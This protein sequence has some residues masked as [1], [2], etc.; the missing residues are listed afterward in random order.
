MLGAKK[1]EKKGEN[2]VD[3]VETEQDE[4]RKEKLNK[5]RKNGKDVAK[6]GE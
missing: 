6:N 5:W 1:F 4:K 3:Y 2:N